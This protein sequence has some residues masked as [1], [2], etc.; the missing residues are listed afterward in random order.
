METK[1]QTVDLDAHLP[2]L[3]YA[4]TAKIG[5]HALRE[6]AKPLKMD[7]CEWRVVQILGRDGASSIN[8]VADRISMD[9]GGTSRA[10]SR[11]EDRG[12]LNRLADKNDRRRSKVA[13]TNKGKNLQEEIAEFANK[14]EELLAEPLS[15]K[16]LDAL[17]LLLGKLDHQ[18]SLM[19][20]GAPAS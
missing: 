14:R 18:A 11:L 20:E 17:I 3:L 7:M 15:K 9:R 1:S 2:A 8:E 12:I 19:L 16:E 10:I 4:L 13:L 6:S 5:Q